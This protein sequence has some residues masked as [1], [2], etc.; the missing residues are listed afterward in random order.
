VS[1][2]ITYNLLWA[3]FKPNTFAY[4]ICPGTQKLRCIKYDFGEERTIS[5]RVVYFYI[6]GYYIDFNRK[7]FGEVLINIGILKFCGSKPINSLDVFPL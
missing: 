7:V 4:T 1:G 2:E 6:K 3:L 5:D